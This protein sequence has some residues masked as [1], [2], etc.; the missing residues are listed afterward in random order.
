MNKFYCTLLI[1]LTSAG[2][3]SLGQ[4]ATD[5][6]DYSLA[7][8]TQDAV[9]IAPSPKY[10]LNPLRRDFK[11]SLP[12]PAGE[13][14]EFEV[15][16]SRFPIYATVG[17]ITFEYLGAVKSVQNSTDPPQPLIKGLNI[18]FTPGP[19]EKLLHLRANAF[20]K[21]ILVA[22]LGVDI[23]DRF[24]S[25]V[26][27]NDLSARLGFKEVH[28]GKKRQIQSSVFDRQSQ[29]I[30]YLTTDL[31]DPD[32]AP[33]AKFLPWQDGMMSILPAIYFLRFQ[34]YKE[35]HLISYPVSYDEVNYQFEILVGKKEKI[36]TECG[37]VK[38]VKLEPKVFGPGQLISRQGEM[39][40]WV[41]DDSRHTPLRLIAKT[42]SGT[43][44]GKLINY[45][46]NCR[47]LDPEGAEL[48][49]ESES[50]KE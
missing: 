1:V 4:T 45:K 46:N 8:Q 3:L 30:K 27:A 17:V 7:N 47:I 21:G 48:R 36:G 42:S 38:T 11:N 34:K 26:D 5:Q 12:I 20:S 13:K 16:L 22:L 43:V 33:R 6:P 28:E 41:T 31:A 49:R 19:E 2:L 25:L 39:T 37:K 15:K 10:P 35:G 9:K 23:K 40:M 24:E 32:A 44:I 14:L 18:E 29:E 50:P